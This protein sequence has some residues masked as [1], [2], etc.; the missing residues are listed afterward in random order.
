MEM[1]IQTTNGDND[2]D[3]YDGGGRQQQ[4]MATETMMERQMETFTLTAMETLTGDK[5]KDE[6]EE[7]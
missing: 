1:T 6:D 4:E 7:Q 3:R 5:V 2:N